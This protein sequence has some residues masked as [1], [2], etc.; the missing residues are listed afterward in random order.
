MKSKNAQLFLVVALVIALGFTIYNV[1]NSYALFESALTV[2]ASSQAGSWNIYINNIDITN[3]SA[4]FTINTI[5]VSSDPNVVSGRMAPGTSA[6]FDLNIVP[7]GTNVSVRYDITFDFSELSDSLVID[8]IEELNNR[9]LVRTDEYTYS[10]IITLA[11]INNNVTSSIR[12][13][14]LWDNDEDNNEIDTELGMDVNS[15]ISIPV[16]ID[17]TQYLGETLVEY[18]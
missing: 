1:R 11:E 12:V 9:T 13:S 5:N 6:Y 17:V 2:E 16:V 8:E 18:E 10:G 14:I 7:T 3:P 15:S 4:N